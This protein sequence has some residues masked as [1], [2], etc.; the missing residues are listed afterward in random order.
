[1]WTQQI[2]SEYS[3][4][5][6]RPNKLALVLKWGM[7][8]AT[9]SA[10]IVSDGEKLYTYI[11]LLTYPPIMGNRYTVQDAPEKLGEITEVGAGIANPGMMYGMFI[12][13]LLFA[14]DPYDKFMK[15]VNAVQYLGTVEL[16]GVPCH[17]LGFSL[18][19]VDWK[20][21]LQTGDEPLPRKIMPD[22]SKKAEARGMKAELEVRLDGWAV[23]VDLTEDQFAFVPP[24]GAEQVETFFEGTTFERQTHPLVGQSAPAFKLALLD[25]GE[26]DLSAHKGRDIV[27]LDFWATWCPQCIRELPILIDVAETYEDRGVVFY[28]VNERE[29]PEK[30]TAFLER[31]RFN[32]RAPLDREG[33]VGALYGVQG[34]P[35]TVVIGKD[36]TVQAVHVG[37]MPGMKPGMKQTLSDELD[38]L[39]AGENLAEEV[40][41]K[42]EA[43]SVPDGMELAWSVEGRYNAVAAGADAGIVYA[44]TGNGQ[45]VEV[46]GAGQ[47][48]RRFRVKDSSSTVRTANL[49][50]DSK[51]E[52]LTFAPLGRSVKAHDAEGNLLWTHRGDLGVVDVWAAD[53]D[54]DGLDEVIIGYTGRRGLHVLD[55]Q[56]KPL[57]KHT[58]LGLGDQW[59]VYVCAGDVNGDQVPEVVTTSARRK[60]HIFDTQGGKIKD[61]DVPYSATMIRVVQGREDGNLILVGGSAVGEK[62]IAVSFDGREEWS[63]TLPGG[64]NHLESAQA[65]HSRPWV[66]VG[67]RGRGGLVYVVDI[68]EGQII[69]TVGG[70]GGRLQVAWLEH[71]S[72]ESPLLVVAT[73]GALR[74]F[75]V[76]GSAAEN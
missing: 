50:G 39:L 26:L 2:N 33:R 60:V 46:D 48:R 30:I 20:L 66:A 29:T 62:L 41:A 18:D 37:F 4:A 51:R 71:E 24:E 16:D 57:W 23:N 9:T 32:L 14:D 65:A 22:L 25:G 54:G 28:A 35:Q 73:G 27:I 6:Q 5:V 58:D 10:T 59:P 49:I 36:G 64:A 69:A 15:G 53:L 21:W 42:E 67:R 52:L 38:A 68:T 7:R 44:V 34:L 72:D 75:S 17:L 56:G 19:E 8:G 70:Q 55:N 11:K 74:A 61:I 12:V 76:T 63:I 31:K 13:T 1:D 3:V 40:R 43:A 47:V 45:C